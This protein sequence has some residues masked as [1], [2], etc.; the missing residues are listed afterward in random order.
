MPDRIDRSR[1]IKL[2][3]SWAE[4]DAHQHSYNRAKYCQAAIIGSTQTLLL[5][6]DTVYTRNRLG[7]ERFV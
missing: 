3:P 1:I 5:A 2:C 7:A 6:G 4:L